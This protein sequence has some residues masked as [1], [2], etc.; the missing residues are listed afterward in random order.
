MFSSYSDHNFK[1]QFY[2]FFDKIWD[3][4]LLKKETVINIP[5]RIF[6]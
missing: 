1:P 5:L 6:Y 2:D 4:N 3:S